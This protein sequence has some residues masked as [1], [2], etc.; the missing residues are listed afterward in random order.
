MYNNVTPIENEFKV[1][2]GW[3]FKILCSAS[4]NPA[5]RYTWSG[6]VAQ[7]GDALIIRNVRTDIERNVTCKAENTMTDSVGKSVVGTTLVTVSMEVLCEYR[8][9]LIL[10]MSAYRLSIKC[11]SMYLTVI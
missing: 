5:P 4:S 6:H 1:I 8:C 3:S 2:E 10:N 7:Q 11:Y 9:A